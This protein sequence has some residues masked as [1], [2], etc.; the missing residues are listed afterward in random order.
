MACCE[1]D[2]QT[3]RAHILAKFDGGEDNVENLI[4]LCPT[5]YKHQEYLSSILANTGH[6]PDGNDLE[7]LFSLASMTR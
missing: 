7:A 6:A 2:P 4:L 5:C 3:E 1:D